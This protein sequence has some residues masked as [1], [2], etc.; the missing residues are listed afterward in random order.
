MQNYGK[1][2]SKILAPPDSSSCVE[3]FEV[4][5]GYKLN[6]CIFVMS[7]VCIRSL[8]EGFLSFLLTFR[9]PSIWPVWKRARE[10]LAATPAQLPCEAIPFFFPGR[11]IIL[12]EDRILP[13][14]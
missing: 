2:L 11:L 1:A 4:A 13:G 7:L 12:N 8:R 10:S 6:H 3:S 5:R 14:D 9:L